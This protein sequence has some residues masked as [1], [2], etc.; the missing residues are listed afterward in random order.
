MEEL[1]KIL[2]EACGYSYD[3][4][5]GLS[6]KGDLPIARQVIWKTLC[7]RGS[8]Y[9]EIGRIFG[10]GHSCIIHGIKHVNDLLSIGDKRVIKCLAEVARSLMI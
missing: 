8:S 3:Q 9:A 7:R 2:S 6:R 1:I 4:I 10:R 5:I